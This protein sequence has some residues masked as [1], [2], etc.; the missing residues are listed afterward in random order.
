MAIASILLQPQMLARMHG[1]DAGA[2]LL[3]ELLALAHKLVGTPALV[4]ALQPALDSALAGLAQRMR[5]RFEPR[6]PALQQRLHGWLAPQLATLGANAWP[7]DAAGLLDWLAGQ[8][9]RLQALPE[10]LADAR[11][12]AAV[13]GLARWLVDELG[14][15]QDLLRD[16]LRRTLADA[17]LALRGL[18]DVDAEARATAQALACLLERLAAEGIA[19]LP[20]FDLGVDRI[21]DLLLAALQ[22]I[23]LET[24]R[25]RLACV[26]GKLRALLQ[27]GAALAGGFPASPAAPRSA[28]PRAAPRAALRATA[29]AARGMAGAAAGVPPRSGDA[30]YCWYG[31]WLYAQRDHGYQRHWIPR[32]PA[33]ELWQSEDGRSL[34]LRRLESPDLV[35]HQA[36]ATLAWHQHPPFKGSKAGQ[37]CFS[38][39]FAPPEFLE[40]FTRVSAAASETGQGLW[41]LIQMTQS[42]Q[43]FGNI[44]PWLWYWLRAGFSAAGLPL[45]PAFARKADAGVGNVWFMTPMLGWIF[46][47]VLSLEGMHTKTGNPGA[48]FGFWMTL[49]GADALNA[50]IPHALIRGGHDLALCVMTLL[51]QSAPADATQPEPLNWQHS[52]KLVEGATFLALWLLVELVPRELYATPGYDDRP[53][54]LLIWLLL[55]PAVGATG[56]MLGSLLGMGL[57]RRPA[58]ERLGIEAGTGAL[59]G[60]RDFLLYLYLFREG[61]TQD[62]RYTP[63][64][65][66][67]GNFFDDDGDGSPDAVPRAE[68]DPLPPK[69][70]SPYRLP[71]DQGEHR[72]VGQAHFGIFSHMPVHKNDKPQIYAIDFAHDYGDEVL[73]CRD[74][75]VVDWFDWVPDD[76]DPSDDEKKAAAQASFKFMVTD[77]GVATDRWR[78]EKEESKRNYIFVRHDE[79]IDAHDK[80]FGGQPVTTY[81]IYMHG[82]EASVRKVFK[83]FYDL[84]PAQIIG[85]RV[86][87]GNP[88]ML[89]GD[90]GMSTHNHLHLH[91]QPGPATPAGPAVAGDPDPRR[92]R[93]AEYDGQVVKA[94]LPFVF[95]DLPGDGVPVKRTWYVSDNVRSTALPP[96]WGAP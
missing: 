38:F 67:N 77:G 36:E 27:G 87:R 81:A 9:E 60:L 74:G 65:D 23:G 49:L 48:W 51:N 92:D 39:A 42:R 50:W 53:E 37:D 47:G 96:Q 75:T 94:T 3:D 43:E 33:D 14:L 56:G 64:V 90:T 13:H 71:Y 69:S 54:V 4:A 24:L 84:E 72:F 89:A 17:A 15:S 6:L 20:R 34:L 22:R 8:L 76:T 63:Q 93:L 26:V 66:R 57:A 2:E 31:S 16:E 82:V 52:D 45:G 59:R 58:W 19:L 32:Y 68:F 40:V 30:T 78:K 80:G 91:L 73:A 21:A 29:R 28:P 95:G 70:S 41:H 88:I 46:L 5:T 25:S 10:A 7:N 85:T 79:R 11:L 18:Q 35:L 1:R 61:D 83:D 86:R 55:A 12:R 44:A 62:G